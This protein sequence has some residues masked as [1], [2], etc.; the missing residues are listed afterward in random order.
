ME[1]LLNIPTLTDVVHVP[2]LA[3]QPNAP[4]A[5]LKMR[6]ICNAVMERLGPQ[7]HAMVAD[8]VKAAQLSVTQDVQRHLNTA[9]EMHVREVLAQ[10]PLEHPLD[11]SP[12]S[13]RTID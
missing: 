6:Q 9:V 11:S 1:A 7:L 13:I 12:N 5:E 4:H 2:H 10:V 8:A 3:S